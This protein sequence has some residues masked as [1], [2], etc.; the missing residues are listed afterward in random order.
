MQAAITHLPGCD[1]NHKPRQHCSSWRPTRD[2]SVVR[3]EP[4]TFA[5]PSS[6]SRSDALGRYVAPGFVTPAFVVLACGAM[7]WTILML[8][9]AVNVDANCGL[10]NCQEDKTIALI[11]LG[12]GWGV[13]GVALVPVFVLLV[14]DRIAR[15]SIA[16][17]IG[18]VMLVMIP[19]AL[20]LALLL[21]RLS[22][23][24]ALRG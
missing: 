21:M 24:P 16:A 3:F 13:I 17:R 14:S 9:W 18:F 19:M 12:F 7:A 22:S 8:R 4:A 5:S 1:L 6:G 20:G 11:L 15:G 23:D 2:A 10:L